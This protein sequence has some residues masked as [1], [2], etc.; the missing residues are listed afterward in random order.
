MPSARRLPSGR[1][2]GVAKAGRTR[3]GTKTFGTRR[4]AL[5]WAERTET[6][7]AGGLDPRAGRAPVRSL[8]PAWI[9]HRRATV[10][11]KTART[12]A[13]IL[14]LCSPALGALAV[15]A[16]TPRH[17]EAWLL[18]LRQHHAQAD[19][20]I[21][22]YRLSLS[23][24]FAWA[25]ADCRLQINPVA[26]A[27]P[28]RPLAPPAEMRPFS[29]PELATLAEAVA[30]RDSVLADVV[31]VLG[32][33][34]LRWAEARSLTAL[35]FSPGST[36]FLRVVRS[37]PE[38]HPVKSTKGGKGRRAPLATPA[39]LAVERLAAGKAPG[40][41]LLT[42]AQGGQ[43]W[44]GTF[45][46]RTD[47]AAISDGRRLHDLRHSAACLWLRR[48]VDVGTVQAWLGHSSITTTQRYLHHLGT[49]AD[50]A[51][52]ARLNSGG[53]YGAHAEASVPSF[54]GTDA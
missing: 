36:P 20:S 28:P 31:T 10:A 30:L 22:R 25:I 5:A 17:V 24:F 13:E 15:A 18:Y 35:D 42:T 23:A 51:G 21:A 29:E 50:A 3:L 32:W 52:L 44:A 26:A 27:K 6:A 12:D 1:W 19:S 43:L 37:Q 46:R 39:L 53:A 4:D 48:G 9:E 8:L 16:V 14:R 41:L 2:Q 34:G 54:E 45:R 11:P 38:G 7:A 40:D 49:S 47:W 33:T